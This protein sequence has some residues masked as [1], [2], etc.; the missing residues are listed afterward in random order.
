MPNYQ[1]GKIYKIVSS[2]TDLVYVG[3][4]CQALSQRMGC[5]RSSTKAH[6]GNSPLH[7][8]MRELGSNA[9]KIILIENYPCSDVSQL[10][11]RE[12]EVMAEFKYRGIKLLNLTT[13]EGISNTTKARLSEWQ[14]GDMHPRFN[15]G[16]VYISNGHCVF[17]WMNGDTRYRKYFAI[18]K[19]GEQEA[20]AMAEEHRDMIYPIIKPLTEPIEFDKAFVRHRV[21]R[22]MQKFRDQFSDKLD[23]RGEVEIQAWRSLREY[24][25]N[26][27]DTFK[28]A[29]A[30]ATGTSNEPRMR[31]FVAKGQYAEEITESYRVRVVN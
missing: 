3:S 9:F 30:K 22:T 13:G 29:L 4:T 25:E 20:Q 5:H 31:K 26:A 28:I 16:S 19:Y 21:A 27:V 6:I 15:R 2:E 17:A 7:E 10:V 8:T 1:N 12:Y 23:D 18:E 24:Y 11:A 14:K